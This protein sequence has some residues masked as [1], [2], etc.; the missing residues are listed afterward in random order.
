MQ[1]LTKICKKSQSSL[2]FRYENTVNEGINLRPIKAMRR[3]ERFFHQC[4]IKWILLE[5]HAHRAFNWPKCAC[6]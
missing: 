1:M 3:D 5:K 2:S 6:I 4:L